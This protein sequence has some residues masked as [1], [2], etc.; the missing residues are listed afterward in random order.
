MFLPEVAGN[1]LGLRSS[2]L[3]AIGFNATSHAADFWL[4]V[5][6]MHTA[7]GPSKVGTHVIQVV[8]Y[9]TFKW[10]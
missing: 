6:Q 4:I 9:A 5:T 7:T 8:Q 10:A 3:I 2:D 1:H